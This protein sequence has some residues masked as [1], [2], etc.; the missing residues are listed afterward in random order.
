MESSTFQAPSGNA[1][2]LH[3]HRGRPRPPGF[4]QFLGLFSERSNS[5]LAPWQ[6]NC[7]DSLPRPVP[8]GLS[9]MESKP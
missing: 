4:G 3:E 7:L 9:P 1:R 6:V 5:L 2:R 8:T